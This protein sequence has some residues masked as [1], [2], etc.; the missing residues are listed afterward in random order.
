M[1][2]D[3]SWLKRRLTVTEAEQMVRD[4]ILASELLAEMRPGDELWEYDSPKEDWDRYMGSS[5]FV[6]VR[7]GIVVSSQVYRMN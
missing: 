5:G 3:P 7:D 6:L 1:T 2:M 4:D